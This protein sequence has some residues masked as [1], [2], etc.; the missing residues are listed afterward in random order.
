MKPKPPRPLSYWKGRKID[1]REAIVDL[2]NAFRFA[3][4][5]IEQAERRLLRR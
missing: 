3:D 4:R 1:L 5:K 2:H